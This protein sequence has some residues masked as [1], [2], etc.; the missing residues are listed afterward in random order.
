[1]GSRDEQL[2]GM[3]LQS[4]AHHVQGK[5]DRALQVLEEALALAEPG[6]FI[7]LFLDEGVP[8]AR[9]LAEAAAHG[10][11]PAYT[12]KLLAAFETETQKT[13]GKTSL[14]SAQ[15]LIEPLS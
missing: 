4:V 6:G 15:P 11:M 3:L 8:M 10:M 13:K 5:E 1:M 12:G 7:R 14:S 2:K 9:V